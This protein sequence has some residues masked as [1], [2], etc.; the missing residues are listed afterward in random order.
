MI[1]VTKRILPRQPGK[2]FFWW[3]EAGLN[4]F[5]CL[6]LSE[7]I[8]D[9]FRASNFHPASG[10]ASMFSAIYWIDFVYEMHQKC[11]TDQYKLICVQ[12]F[13]L[14]NFTCQIGL[15]LDWKSPLRDIGRHCDQQTSWHTRMFTL[16]SWLHFLYHVAQF[17]DVLRLNYTKDVERTLVTDINT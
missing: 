8:F 4:L 10:I 14:C 3:F 5:L 15:V 16:M 9:I 13:L 7:L 6:K 2:M 1:E 17:V 11:T 12:L